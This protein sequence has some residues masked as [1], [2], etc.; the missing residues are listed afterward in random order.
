[1]KKAF[2]IILIVMMS[3]SVIGVYPGQ[4]IYS[5]KYSAQEE[6][7]TAPSID[8]IPLL[9]VG[10]T[11]FRATGGRGGHNSFYARGSARL[12]SVGT[13]PKPTARVNLKVYDLPDS[14]QA[15]AQFEA[16]LIDDQTEYRLSLGTFTTLAAGIGELYYNAQLYFDVYDR[17]EVTMEPFNDLDLSPGPTILSGQ[18]P[19]NAI[20]PYAY[21]ATQ[22]KNRQVIRAFD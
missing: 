5:S 7:Y 11:N 10:E 12:K 8:F 18:I 20:R 15:N 1:M 9:P 21:A 17:I 3:I 2:L 6:K 19:P 16:W 13:Y 22:P 14:S 4:S